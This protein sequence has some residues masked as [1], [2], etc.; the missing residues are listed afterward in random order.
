MNASNIP[1]YWL[2]QTL[3]DVPTGDY[4]L[5]DSERSRVNS[6]HIA[7]RRQEWRLGRWTAKRAVAAYLQRPFDRLSE[8]EIRAGLSGAPEIAIKGV[9]ATP[10]ISISHCGGSAVCIVAAPNSAIGCDLERVEP[11]TDAFYETFFTDYERKE[12][13]KLSG[14]DR[15]V[16]ACVMWC[17]KESYLKAIHEGLRRDTRDVEVR[18]EDLCGSIQTNGEK[19]G[20]VTWCRY[21]VTS[22]NDR[23]SGFWKRNTDF[24]TAVLSTSSCRAQLDLSGSLLPIRL[25]LV[26]VAEHVSQECR[27]DS[28]QNGRCKGSRN[29]CLHLV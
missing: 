27:V 4:W 12:L 10:S 26:I 15:A 17:A 13:G 24:V 3:V 6:L 20:T 1:I 11:R 8:I 7:K 23:A 22:G 14:Y 9:E 21:R 25:H 5:S 2:E 28:E 19:S 18:L 16:V 29:Q